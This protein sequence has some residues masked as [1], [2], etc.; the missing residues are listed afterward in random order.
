MIACMNDG[1]IKL[2]ELWGRKRRRKT[3]YRKFWKLEIKKN[4]VLKMV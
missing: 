4:K 3:K 2:F 1:V